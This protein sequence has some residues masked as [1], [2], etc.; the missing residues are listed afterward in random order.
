MAAAQGMGPGI[1]AHREETAFSPSGADRCQHGRPASHWTTGPCAHVHTHKSTHTHGG[2]R[3]RGGGGLSGLG[4]LSHGH[5]PTPSVLEG[6]LHT[7]PRPLGVPHHVSWGGRKPPK[8]ARGC[9]TE[10][11][12]ATM[13]L[14]RHPATQG[15]HCSLT[16][17]VC[18]EGTLQLLSPIASPAGQLGTLRHGPQSHGWGAGGRVLP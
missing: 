1:S 7:A 13:S 16:S 17:H 5:A 12:L 10:A 18:A 2:Q 9:G 14:G 11:G 8:L 15:S 6:G 4:L 3:L